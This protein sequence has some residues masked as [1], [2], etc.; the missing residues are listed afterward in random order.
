MTSR[1]S[2][3]RKPQK[4]DEYFAS[5]ENQVP[6]AAEKTTV[7]GGDVPRDLLHPGAVRMRRD[8]SDVYRPGSNIDEEEDVIGDESLECTYF[9][10]QEIGR[11]QAFPV[12][13]DERRPPG[14][15]VTLGSWLD[16]L[17]GPAPFP[18]VVFRLSC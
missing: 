4:S 14:M 12:S 17:F 11:R 6:R 9:D 10:A 3:A 15:S 8:S 13:F 7:H 2:R 16:A 1:P 5:V 18:W